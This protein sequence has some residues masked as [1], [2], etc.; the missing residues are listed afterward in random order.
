MMEEAQN[1]AIG[2]S[3]GVLLTWLMR[4]HTNMKDLYNSD[5]YKISLEGD[6]V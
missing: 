6:K 5:T 3:D 1:H 4:E 2:L